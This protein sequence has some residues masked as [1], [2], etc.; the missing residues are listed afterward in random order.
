M[1][2]SVCVAGATGWAGRPVAEAVL[3]AP[4]LDLVNAVSRR[5]AGIDL[6]VV[7]GGE[8]NAVPVYGTVAEAF[9]S[10]DVLVDFTGHASVRQHA[11][12]AVAQAVDVVVGSS[13]LSEDDLKDLER[14][15]Q[16]QGVGV[17][18]GGNYALS[19][20][21]LV[22]AAL[23]L[24]RYLPAWEIVEYAHADKVDVPS[25]TA[26]ELAERLSRVASPHQ[27]VPVELTAG[28]K[29]ARGADVAGTRVHSV[30]LPGYELTVD[31]V[32]GLAVERLTL[33]YDGGPG[34]D[35]FVTGTL[36]A[37][38]HVPTVTGIVCGL[39]SLL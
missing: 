35:K 19:A 10:A 2:L 24:V 33:R 32:F 15:A 30:R 37:I 28:P 25:G 1:A 3:A 14:A 34:A 23:E 12:A 18:A 29:E 36:M 5:C 7:W 13:G 26:R 22:M 9:R 20:C 38:R 6:G 31:L 27:E 11:E 4:D 21:L 17:F 8:P 39:D 16:S